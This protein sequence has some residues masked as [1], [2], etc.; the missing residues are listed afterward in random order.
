MGD[1]ECGEHCGEA[2]IREGFS[3]YLAEWGDLP[4]AARGEVAAGEAFGTRVSVYY[5]LLEVVDWHRYQGVARESE[6]NGGCQARPGTDVPSAVPRRPRHGMTNENL[7]RLEKVVLAGLHG[8]REDVGA[9]RLGAWVVGQATQACHDGVVAGFAGHGHV[10]DAGRERGQAM[11][12]AGRE[13]S[14]VETAPGRVLVSMV[15]PAC[16]TTVR[17]RAWQRGGMVVLLRRGERLPGVRSW[18]A[19]RADGAGGLRTADA[20]SGTSGR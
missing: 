15:R 3:L 11:R 17:P 13:E 16:G 2:E 19:A 6:P 20:R 1:L 9:G 18:Q 10:V 7:G 12:H 4:V 8:A 5:W 14:R